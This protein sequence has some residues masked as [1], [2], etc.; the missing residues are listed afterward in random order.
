MKNIFYIILLSCACVFATAAETAHAE[1]SARFA[2]AMRLRAESGESSEVS[3]SLF[4]KAADLF[5]SSARE[6]WRFWFEAGNAR[7]WAGDGAGAVIAYRRY[8]A[9]DPFNPG[10]GITFPARAPLQALFLHL[11]NVFLVGPGTCG[12]LPLPRFF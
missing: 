6:D 8:L 3:D 11:G 9:R 5:E 2:E 4:T 10:C 7:W 12:W 1:A